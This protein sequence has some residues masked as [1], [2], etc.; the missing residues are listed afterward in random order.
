[1]NMLALAGVLDTEIPLWVKVLLGIALMMFALGVAGRLVFG[2]VRGSI[3][4]LAAALAIVYIYVLGI[5]IGENNILFS[6]LPFFGDVGDMVNISVLI[7]TDFVGFLLEAAKMFI[8]AVT[9]NVLESILGQEDPSFSLIGW[10]F[11]Y[12]KQCFIMVGGLV[13][14][15]LVTVALGKVSPGLAK[16]LP[17][18]ILLIITAAMFLTVLK[19]IFK[20]AA[21][22]ANPFFGALVS[23]FMGNGF[24]R[25][26][27]QAF[28]TTLFICIITWLMGK[29]G[30]YTQLVNVADTALWMSVFVPVLFVLLAILYICTV[31]F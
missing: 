24:G 14:N 12:V 17:V 11:W 30:I 26:I 21:F 7:Q 5:S 20:T 4:S 23:F 8:L 15:Y 16:W 22:F 1:M 18:I 27:T 29:Y 25:I 19:I 3:K 13:V 9:V 2:E 10:I 6:A 31:L 28:I